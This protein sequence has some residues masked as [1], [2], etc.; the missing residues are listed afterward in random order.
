MLSVDSITQGIVIDHIKAGKGMEIY[1]HLNLDV[2]DYPV[3]IIK[4]VKSSKYGKKDIIKVE[5]SMDID[6]DVLGYIDPNITVNI[7]KDEKIV[8]KVNLK[9]PE[10][11]INVIKCKNP[12]CITTGEMGINHIF[13]LTDAEKGEYRC[14][15]CQQE[16]REHHMIYI[17]GD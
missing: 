11:L 12:R 1:K 2:L 15:Y 13:T 17:G 9:L 4:N 8:D 14:E 6:F 7:V 10:K 16:N 3:A 5:G